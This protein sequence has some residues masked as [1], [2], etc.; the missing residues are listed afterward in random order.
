MR[1]LIGRAKGGRSAAR[2]PVVRRSRR[3][4]RLRGRRG[5]VLS[6]A[7]AVALAA[8]AGGV[9]QLHRTGRFEAWT[10]QLE[11][12][13][14]AASARLGLVVA[15]IEVEGRA[16]TGREAIL[17]AVGATRGT[18][19]LGV[20]PS[21]AKAQLEALP[22]VRSAAV[23]RRLPGT[24]FIRLVERQPFA[25]WQRQGKLVL[26]DRDGV[27]ITDERLD[28]FPGLIVIV[29]DEAP[30]RAAAL[31]DMLA[32]QP[33]IAG[34]V[35]AAVLVGGRR[36]NLQLDNGIDVELPEDGPEAAWARL[37]QL[38]HSSRLLARD[39]QTVDMRL[40]DRLVVRVN[41]EPAKEPAR[42]G[43]TAAKNT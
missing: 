41:P 17:R 33:D 7:L 34:R 6:A 39:V 35:V 31:I 30:H 5:L 13:A 21:Q 4:A 18:P 32:T 19:I 9:F 1:P 37:A 14:L 42:K 27:V 16:M 26:I 23:E 43:R 11:A 10:A 24:L 3:F 2:P 25:F 15:D 28:R 8:V 38:E 20:S 36:W 29:G 22:W 40:P 12:G